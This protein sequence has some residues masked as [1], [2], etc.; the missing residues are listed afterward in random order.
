MH[1]HSTS[2]RPFSVLSGL[3]GIAGVVL[4]LVSFAIN[5][6]PPPDATSAE[7]AEQAVNVT[8]CMDNAVEL[9]LVASV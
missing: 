4:I 2:E 6:G 9:N 8:S 1:R 7:L 5:S 3:S